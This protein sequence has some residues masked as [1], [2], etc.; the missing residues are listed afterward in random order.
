MSI[1]DSLDHL[2]EIYGEEITDNLELLRCLRWQRDHY[3]DAARELQEK[4]DEANEIV[5]DLSESNMDLRA[6]AN[7]AYKR[8]FELEKKEVA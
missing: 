3:K 6:M 2:A 4:L 5:A 1:T 8:M 7:S